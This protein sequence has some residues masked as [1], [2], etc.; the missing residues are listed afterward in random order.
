MDTDNK[1]LAVLKPE[2]MTI[3]EA[4][5]IHEL[6]STALMRYQEIEVD[7]SLI[8][9]IDSA[10]LQLL[11]A[12]KSDGLKQK[13]SIIYTAH[14]REVIELLTLFNMTQLFGDPVVL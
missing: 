10:G 2:N 12:L 4:L 1:K 7:L 8:T 5:E 14:S 6:F 13:K 11:V 9:E 3:Y